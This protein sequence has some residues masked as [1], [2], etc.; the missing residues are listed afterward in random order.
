MLMLVGKPG[1]GKSTLM[2]KMI[3]SKKF[4]FHKFDK[5]FIVS[6]SY[7]KLSINVD[8]RNKIGK[9]SLDWIF[10]KIDS[11]NRD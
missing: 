2:Q 3:T 1:S 8:E 11:L 6:P 4:Y 7:Q 5:I 10:N 9:F